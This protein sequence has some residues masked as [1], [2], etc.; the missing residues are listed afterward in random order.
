MQPSEVIKQT[1]SDLL[2]APIE[3]SIPEE[4]AQIIPPEIEQETQDW[5]EEQESPEKN[6]QDD[7]ADPEVE[8]EF[9]EEFKE[10][11]SRKKKNKNK[12]NKNSPLPA[13]NTLSVRMYIF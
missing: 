10:V 9:E 3:V 5:V 4:T 2:P 12:K 6:Q 13:E 7:Q 8:E 11:A 1:D